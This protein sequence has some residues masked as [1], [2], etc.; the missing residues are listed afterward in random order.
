MTPRERDRFDNLLQDVIAELPGRIRDLLDEVPLIVEDAPSPDLV[1]HL[2]DDGTLEPGDDGSDL[3]GLHSGVQITDRSVEHPADWGGSM[4]YIRL[5]RDA[6]VD[7][8][9]GWDHVDE[10]EEDTGPG[11]E[12]AIIEE[13]HITLL[14]EIGHH[15][16]LDEAD[17]DDLG[18]A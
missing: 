13:I 4:E 18:Y 6:I 7:L 3:C 15:F 2:I 8:A 16:G 10:P 17:L 5:F 9:G 1:R 11:G 14:H 12:E